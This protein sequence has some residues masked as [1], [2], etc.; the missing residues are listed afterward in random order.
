MA[1]HCFFAAILLFV[2]LQT[3]VAESV[4]VCYG[5]NGDDLPSEA[6]VV[7]LYK[8]YGISSMR[9]YDPVPPVLDALRGSQIQVILCIPNPT[10]QSLTD[11]VAAN[12]WV[13][14]FVKNYYPDVKFKYLAVG[15]EVLPNTPS[16][17]FAAFVLPAMQN[18]YNSLAASG[19]E[20]E[21]KV[22]TATFSAILANTYPPA[23]SVF[24]DD[25]REFAVP[26]LQF[27]AEKNCPLLANIYP[28]F[29]RVGDPDNVPLAFAL[30]ENSVPN[31][32]GY[33]NLFDAMLDG[34]YY[35]AAKVAAPNIDIVVSET[36]WPSSGGGDD[37]TTENAEAYYRNMISHVKNG[38][39]TPLKPGKS[40][41]VYLFAMF[42]ENLKIGDETEKHFG[43]FSPDQKPKYQISLK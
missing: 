28:Y 27:L 36:G 21:I 22:S 19:L 1:T 5:R 17:E 35:A 4:G 2:T 14:T 25:A 23:E 8:Q 20:E 39:G 29:A 6:Q 15:N 31:D 32:A 3:T 7:N 33:T 12:K 34:F 18:V 26:I 11:P 38:T 24:R 37:A 42:D 43:L 30:F 40:M 9:V 41:E 13:Q 10:L 16:G